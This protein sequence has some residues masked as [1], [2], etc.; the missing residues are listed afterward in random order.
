MRNKLLKITRGKQQV[1]LPT[2]AEMRL[3]QVLWD[4]EEATVDEVVNAHPEKERPNYKTTQTLLRIMEQKGFITHET[5]GRVFVFRTLVSRKTIDN[6]SVQA[7]VSRNFRGSAAGLLINLLETSSI[8][9]KELD[10]LEAYLREYRK[11]HET[12][13]HGRG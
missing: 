3:L 9:K 5:R 13:D 11:K 8:K 7:L 1:S 10:E 6:L 2:P 12:R 4:R